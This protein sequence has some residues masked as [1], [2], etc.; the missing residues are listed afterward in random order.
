MFGS[1]AAGV[2]R[3]FPGVGSTADGRDESS[4]GGGI[5]EAAGSERDEMPGRG[6]ARDGAPVHADGADEGVVFI[7][8]MRINSFWKL[9]RWVPVLLAAPRLVRELEAEPESALLGSW[10]FLSPPRTIGFV[11]YWESAEALQSYARDPD[12]GHVDAWRTYAE[13]GGDGAVGVWHETYPFEE[14][15][16]LYSD[17]PPR[18]LGAVAG[19]DLVP[20]TGAS[21]TGAD[22]LDASGE[23]GERGAVDSG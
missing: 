13:R 20:A 2:R 10:T 8:G 5:G 4:D 11:Q 9:H 18:G 14:Y 17:V 3:A 12:R 19:T 21:E 7:V 23:A 6:Y 1:I 22:R 16:T 15:E